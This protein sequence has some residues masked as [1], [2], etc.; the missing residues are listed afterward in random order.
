M[1]AKKAAP[2]KAAGKPQKPEEPAM[3][4]QLRQA[5][6]ASG[7]SLY[8]IAKATGIHP[9][10]VERFAKGE[11]DIVFSNAARIAAVLNLMLTESKRE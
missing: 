7:L 4:D 2:K 1:A 5:M 8:A 10:N 6:K 11:T 9:S 3:V